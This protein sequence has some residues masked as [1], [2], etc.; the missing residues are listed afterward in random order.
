MGRP[1]VVFDPLNKDHR[2]WFEEFQRLNTWGRCPVRFFADDAG[3]L[4]SMIQKSLIKFYV[5]KEFGVKNER[6]TRSIGRNSKSLGK[7]QV[8]KP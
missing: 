6:R 2:R 5:T 8:A 7:K 1:W 3:D 4:V